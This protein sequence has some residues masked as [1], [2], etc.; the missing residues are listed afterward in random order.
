MNLNDKELAIFSIAKCIEA[1][2]SKKKRDAVFSKIGIHIRMN[3]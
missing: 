2:S 3:L 1:L